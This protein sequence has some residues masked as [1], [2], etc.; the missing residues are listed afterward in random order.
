ML[1]TPR[2]SRRPETPLD[3]DMRAIAHMKKRGK[4][5]VYSREEAFGG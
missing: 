4:A 3:E 5:R 2:K 1:A